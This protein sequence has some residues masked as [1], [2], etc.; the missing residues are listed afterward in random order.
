MLGLEMHTV[1]TYFCLLILPIHKW[2]HKSLNTKK[3][4]NS[5]SDLTCWNLL[6][7]ANILFLFISIDDV[8]DNPMSLVIIKMKALIAIEKQIRES[9]ERE[10]Q[11]RSYIIDSLVT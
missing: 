6:G 10:C 11:M 8:K 2:L 3:L 4:L 7:F 1:S 9:K 5:L